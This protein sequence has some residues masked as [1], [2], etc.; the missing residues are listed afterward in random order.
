M[1]QNQTLNVRTGVG[2]PVRMNIPDCGNSIQMHAGHLT[3][4]R[5]FWANAGAFCFPVGDYDV[6]HTINSVPL[7]TSAPFIITFESKIPRFWPNNRIESFLNNILVEKLTSNQCV[8]LLAMSEYAQRAAIQANPSINS[9]A[10]LDKFEVLYPHVEL[11]RNDPKECNSDIRLL[12][13]G[14]DCMRKGL[15][16]LLKAHKLLLKRN[17][18]IETHVVSSLQCNENDYFGPPDKQLITDT[19]GN[20]RLPNIIHYGQVPNETVLQLMEHCD[21]LVLPT[22]HDTFGYVSIEAMSC[23]TPVI[24]TAT[25]AQPEIIEH[26]KSGFL[27]PFDVDE[28]AGK[29]VWFERAGEQGYVQAY[30]QQV[31]ALAHSI[32]NVVESVADDR[33]RYEALS[34]GALTQAHN[35]FGKVRAV[36]RLRQLYHSAVTDHVPAHE[37]S[38]SSEDP[39]VIR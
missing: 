5:K 6:I 20:L 29:W 2:Y 35:K 19:V 10:L 24:A 32:A 38:L 11:K 23:G 8:R 31:D 30:V 4:L 18:K 15:P 1:K 26:G 13:V 36:K 7:L 33:S 28:Q 16:A 39:L 21:F 3:P 12:F 25:C 14:A 34:E 17:V 9:P 37:P 22:F 27:L